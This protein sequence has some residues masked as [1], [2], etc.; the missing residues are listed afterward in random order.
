ME[1]GGNLNVSAGDEVTEL[2]GIFEL[3]SALALVSSSSLDPKQNERKKKSCSC[4][5]DAEKEW[6]KQGNLRQDNNCSSVIKR[7]WQQISS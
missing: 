7:Y 4:V 5:G 1:A 3:Y 6:K 2:T